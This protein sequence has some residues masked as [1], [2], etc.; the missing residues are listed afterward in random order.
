MTII[1]KFRRLIGRS[2]PVL[3]GPSWDEVLGNADDWRL[4]KPDMGLNQQ[5]T[6]DRPP[7]PPWWHEVDGELSQAFENLVATD[8]ALASLL[9]TH[10][11]DADSRDDYPKLVALGDVELA[12]CWSHMRRNFYELATRSPAPIA[13]EAHKR[14]AE[15]YA[16]EKDIR[17]HSAEERRLIRQQKGR[18]MPRNS[19][20][21]C[22]RSSV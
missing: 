7:L 9:K 18:P 14:I 17:G 13:S 6:G 21:G 8:A 20:G 12:F 1:S 3:P 16:I 15:V 10:G 4:P 2:Q 22:T 19:N 5:D 11:D